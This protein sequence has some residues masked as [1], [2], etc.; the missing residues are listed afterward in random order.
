MDSGSL[1]HKLTVELRAILGDE[2]YVLLTQAIGGTRLYVAHQ[3]RDD[4]DVVQAL[5]RVAADK[6]SRA[7]AP[8]NI[9]VPLARRERALYWRAKGLSNALIARKIGI[10]ESGVDKLFAREPNLPDRP[11][12]A[13]NPAQLDL[14]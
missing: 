2:G 10:T 11:G 4:N 12:S 5:G 13:K 7:L 9:R 8:A 1:H 6:L 3:F 14:F